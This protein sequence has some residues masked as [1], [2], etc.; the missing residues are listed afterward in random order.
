MLVRR[1]SSA[2]VCL[3]CELNIARPRLPGLS[4]RAPHASF[5]TSSCR[6]DAFDEE[7]QKKQIR[8]RETFDEE[9]KKKQIRARVYALNRVRK[10]KGQAIRQ[11]SAR[12]DGPKTL[13]EDSSIIVLELGGGK[14]EKTPQVEPVRDDGGQISL[15]LA[16]AIDM[17]P[18]TLEEIV[19][20]LDKLCFTAA[21]GRPGLDGEKFVTQAVFLNLSKHLLLAFT[22][23]QLSHYYSVKKNV[24]K[25]RVAHQV[26]KGVKQLQSKVKRPAER[27][28]WAPGTTHLN[29]RLPGLDVHHHVKKRKS[30]SKHLLVDQILRDVWKLEMFEELEAAGE[31]ELALSDWQLALLTA[32]GEF[33]LHPV[34]ILRAN[35]C[36]ATETPLDR[37]GKARIAKIDVVPS[38]K[39]LRITADKFTAEYAADDIE[40]LLQKSESRRLHFKPWVPHLKTVNG[41]VPSINDVFPESGEVLRTVV[42]MTGAYL[43]RTTDSVSLLLQNTMS[44]TD[45]SRS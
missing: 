44:R 26:I 22:V 31:L 41:I 4:H 30:V 16:D 24:D 9:L 33:I 8:G 13:G 1:A 36:I 20:Q 3:R 14:K 42:T 21:N 6:R 7:L 10:S 19:D 38:E 39:V 28:E 18:A 37:I 11:K 27:S 23:P 32:G 45:E 25:D 2:F 40:Q 12:L 29:R 17:K 43:Q 35:T 34:I 15:N 5:S